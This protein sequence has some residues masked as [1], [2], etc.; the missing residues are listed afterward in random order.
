M[1][2]SFTLI[3]GTAIATAAAIGATV[4]L[5]AGQDGNGPKTVAVKTADLEQSIS[6]SGTLQAE[7][8]WTISHQADP[9]TITTTVGGESP[10]AP[11]RGGSAA[12]T[13][14]TQQVPSTA[15]VTAL[16]A[17][18]TVIAGGEV[19]YTADGEPTL[20]LPG[21]TAAWRTL[22]VGSAD[23]P[24][25]AQL[26]TYLAS[27]GFDPG[28]LD[29]H[30]DASTKA[31]VQAWQSAIGRTPTGAVELGSVVFAPT[32]LTV[33]STAVTV[34]ATVS[35]GS[36]VMVVRSASLVVELTV[37]TE[38]SPWLAVGDELQVRLPD[39]STTKATVGAIVEHP[40]KGRLALATLAKAP[41]VPAT[42]V[43]I[44]ATRRVTLASAALVVPAGSIIHLEGG[45][46][47]VRLATGRI[48]PVT[49]TAI[50][51]ANVAVTSEE[52]RQG[53]TVVVP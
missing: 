10:E 50:S 25:V 6:A 19:L 43:T 28:D 41:A 29:A 15:R 36:A 52:L 53:D 39:R 27:S 44:T 24:D 3:A 48:V 17:P 33:E 21:A 16:P 30:Y 1:R 26:E 22:A 32:S 34:G 18:G 23:G 14:V 47:A 13:T 9:D 42:P 40:T 7:E 8:T 5:A 51:G 12:P 4:G 20:L 2:P 46:D 45:I 38:L 37:G 35:D 11:A 49:I 31:A